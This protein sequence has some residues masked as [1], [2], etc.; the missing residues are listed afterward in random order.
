[1]EIVIDETLD[2][3]MV[4]ASAPPVSNQNDCEGG[5]WNKNT[6]EL[7]KSMDPT[8]TAGSSESPLDTEVEDKLR[9]AISFF[10]AN[11]KRSNTR[12]G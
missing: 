9:D 11:R 6:A 7:N 2:P 5:K 10:R 12:G 1:M 8:P 4:P 3:V